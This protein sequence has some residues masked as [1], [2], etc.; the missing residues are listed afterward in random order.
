MAVSERRKA[1]LRDWCKR[2]PKKRFMRYLRHRLKKHYGLTVPIYKMLIKRQG[3]L[4]AICGESME[5]ATVS[6][7]V[8]NGRSIVV[9]HIKGT[10]Q[11]RGL[12]HND[13]NRALGFFK[14]NPQVLR[15]AA[16]YLE[17]PLQMLDWRT[18]QNILKEQS[19]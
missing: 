8:R 10:K 13:C 12:L 5:I 18:V 11:V 14:D 16:E 7:R 1:M 2:N 15:R 3:G 6:N 19:K 4:C 17:N 9:D